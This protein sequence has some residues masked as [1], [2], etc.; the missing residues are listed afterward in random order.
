[1]A[2][3]SMP[4]RVLVSRA[5]D[6]LLSL[7]PAAA[8]AAERPQLL[9]DSELRLTALRYAPA[10]VDIHWGGWI[11]GGIG[12][13]RYRRTTAYL[14]GDVET[15]LGVERRPFEA[16]QANYH[17]ELGVRR[18]MPW[19]E[20]LAYFHHV[21][22]HAVDREKDL[23]VDWNVLTAAVRGP[24]RLPGRIPGL[25]SAS[26]GTMTQQSN[27]GYRWETRASAQLDLLR[28]GWGTGFA[29]AELHLMK[30]RPNALFPRTGFYDAR[31]EGGLRVMRERRTVELFM[32]LERR[33]DIR[34]LTPAARRRAMI[35]LR[36]GL[37]A[38]KTADEPKTPPGSS[39]W[40][41]L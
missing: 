29:A 18:G 25:W 41:S 17:L 10:E 5:L 36:L 12:V 16:N 15:V 19:G 27:V 28:R 2:P 26:V 33:N 1:M 22:R 31:V 37:S 38:G 23:P 3:V 32:A 4:R 9:P 13:L 35:G 20:A 6:L 21:S 7:L 14:E 30:T 40:C 8:L 39:P 24:L 34:L 11:G